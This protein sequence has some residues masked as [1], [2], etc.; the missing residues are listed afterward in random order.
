[1]ILHEQQQVNI[2]E[3][4]WNDDGTVTLTTFPGGKDHH[5]TMRTST[6]RDLASQLITA[7]AEAERAADDV[8]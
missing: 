3:A 2:A 5:T 4:D 6:A 1:M 8:N 7:A